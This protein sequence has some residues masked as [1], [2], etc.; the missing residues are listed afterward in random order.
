MFEVTLEAVQNNLSRVRADIEGA[1]AKSDR[2]PDE[3]ELLV[4]TKYVGVED[5][6]VLAE[7][8]LDLVGEN[9]A[10][11]LIEKKRRWGDILSWD[12]I[13]SVQSRKVRDILPEVRLIHSVC[14]DSVVS[15]IESKANREVMALL[16]VN[17]SRESSKAGLDVRDLDSFIEKASRCEHLNFGGL[18]T[19]PPLAE[20]PELNRRYFSALR[21]RAQKLTGSWSPRHEFSTLSMG[22]S[23]DYAVAVEEGATIVRLGSALLRPLSR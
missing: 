5:M 15:Q 17:L 14:S 2:H 7:A 16:Q 6:G 23:Q 10:Q 1:C 22:T 4:A 9:R 3:V 12:F 18:M 21:E 13:G 19:M 8:G 11:D 20:S